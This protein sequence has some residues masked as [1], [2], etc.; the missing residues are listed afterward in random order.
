MNKNLF[1]KCSE[2][3]LCKINFDPFLIIKINVLLVDL[4]ETIFRTRKAF[5]TPE[6]KIRNQILKMINRI[7]KEKLAD[8]EK[9][10][11]KL[12]S[13]NSKKKNILSYAGI[14]KDMDD[15]L[16]KEFTDQLI[17]RRQASKRRNDEKSP[18]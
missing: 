6:T 4:I 5:M 12:E 17:P 7:P 8:I 18:D 13:Q 1:T 9:Y 15:D 14:W 3:F 2:A 11:E 10:L 16:L